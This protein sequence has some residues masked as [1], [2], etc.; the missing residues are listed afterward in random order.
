LIFTAIKSTGPTV[1]SRKPKEFGCLRGC[2]SQIDTLRTDGGRPS[3]DV[4][5]PRTDGG[6]AS[7]HSPELGDRPTGVAGVIHDKLQR[8]NRARN[9]CFAEGIGVDDEAALEGYD[10]AEH[11]ITHRVR[12]Y[13]HAVAN[14]GLPIGPMPLWLWW[15]LVVAISTASGVAIYYHGVVT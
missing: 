1:I 10:R 6:A 5:Q 4:E 11:P 14:S 13:I 3:D 9:H 15:L 12:P 7:A 2:E 8:A